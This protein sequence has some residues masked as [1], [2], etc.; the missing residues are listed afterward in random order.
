MGSAKQLTRLQIGGILEFVFKIKYIKTRY[1]VI[2]IRGLFY[3]D[4]IRISLLKL[5]SRNGISV[6]HNHTVS[7][8]EKSTLRRQKK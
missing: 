4:L 6:K 5:S 8:V 1:T 7:G 2:V 3:V